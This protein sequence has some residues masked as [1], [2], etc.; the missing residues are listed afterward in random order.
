MASC[1]PL[2]ARLTLLATVVALIGAFN[3]YPA[4]LIYNQIAGEQVTVHITECRYERKSRHCR[5]TWRDSPG[6]CTKG[7][8]RRSGTARKDGG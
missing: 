6:G 5:G 3:C 8:S 2:A 7:P 1:M 4:L